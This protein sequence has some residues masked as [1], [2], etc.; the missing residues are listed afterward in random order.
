MTLFDESFLLQLRKDV[1]R[2]LERGAPPSRVNAARDDGTTR[3]PVQQTAHGF[4]VGQGVKN[5]DGTWVS[6][7]GTDSS[8]SGGLW[9]IVDKVRSPDRFVVTCIG[10]VFIPGAAL[11]AAAYGFN[12][13]GVLDDTP[14]F[15]PVKRVDSEHVLIASGGGTG[16]ADPTDEG[17][18]PNSSGDPLVAT[19]VSSVVLGKQLAGGGALTVYTGAIIGGGSGF[20][21]L[22]SSGLHYGSSDG[23]AYFTLERTGRH[24]ILRLYNSA[25]ST[26]T[27]LLE[28]D[29]ALIPSTAKAL[30]IREEDYC[31]SGTP[32]KRLVL[33]SAPYAAS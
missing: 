31:D 13:S 26:G 33:A 22:S 11:T 24:A 19:W 28:I 4:V 9:G 2:L 15:K 23:D 16:I 12:A 20:I 25:V 17:Q 6:I 1:D 14:D 32:T 5:D 3:I 18:V 27:P 8:Y 10:V 29:T 7:D 30:A 21:T